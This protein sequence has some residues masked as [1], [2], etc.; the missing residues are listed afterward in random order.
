MPF[1][2]DRATRGGWSPLAMFSY[3]V[4]GNKTSDVHIVVQVQK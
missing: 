3:K 2:M 1:G 4:V